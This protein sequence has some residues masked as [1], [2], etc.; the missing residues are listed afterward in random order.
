[1]NKALFSILGIASIIMLGCSKDEGAVDNP[2]TV[3][4]AKHWFVRVQGPVTTSNYSLFSTRTTYS[5]KSDASGG[6]TETLLTDTITLDDHN[7]LN[8]TWRANIRID[9]PSRT[10]GA[11]EYKNWHGADNVVVKE[12]KMFRNGGKSRSGRVVDSIYLIYAFKSA[13]TVNYTLKGHARSGYV[14][15]DY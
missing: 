5:T 3:N 10:F 7:L 13:P 8:P 2:S 12:G 11:G 1:M 6:Q 15:D 9:A 14:A 4:L